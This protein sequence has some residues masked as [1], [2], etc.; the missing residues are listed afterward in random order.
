M[1]EHTTK[2]EWA[3]VLSKMADDGKEEVISHYF[4]LGYQNEI[5]RQFLSKYHDINISLIH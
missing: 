3:L 5:T 4:H 2:R 1:R